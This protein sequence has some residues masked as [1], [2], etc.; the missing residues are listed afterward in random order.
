MEWRHYERGA[1]IIEQGSL[2][3]GVDL[4]VSGEVIVERSSAAGKPAQPIAKLGPGQI[5]G[6]RSVL[7]NEAT[8]ATVRAISPVKCL[9]LAAASFERLLGEFASLQHWVRDLVALRDRSQ[10][11]IDL[12]LRHSFLRPLGRDDLDRFI[13]SGRVRELQA[14]EPLVRAGERSRDV[15]FVISG[16]V[17][18]YAPR[19]E[20]RPREELAVQGAGWLFGHAAALLDLPRTADV[21]PLETTEILEVRAEALMTIVD[22]NPTVRRRLYQDLAQIDLHVEAARES[23]SPSMLVS[24]YG[25]SRALGTTSI[26]YA[27]AAALRDEAAVVL[28]DLEGRATADR[29]GFGVVE[30]RRLDLEVCRL[31]TPEDW[32]LDVVWPKR[33]EDVLG[34]LAKLRDAASPGSYVL[35]AAESMGQ[36]DQAAMAAAEAVVFVRWAS[37]RSHEEAA[38]RGQYRV[39]AVRLERGA[40]L[41]LETNSRT[42]RVA[43]DPDTVSRFWRSG[44]L[45]VLVD[46][47]RKFGRAA[48]RLMRVLLGRSVGLALGG[49]GALGFSHIGLI[50][51]LTDARI[52]IDYVSGASFG[53]LVA[54]LY[55]AGGIDALGELIKRR[56]KLLR[57]AVFAFYST[58][59]FETF[60]DEIVGHVELGDTEVPFFPVAVDISTG[61][62]VVRSKGT[63]GHGVRSSSCLPG[64]YPTLSIG[65]QRLVDGGMNNNVPASVVWEAGAHFI[66]ASNIIPS[67]PFGRTSTL[68]TGR[69]RMPARLDSLVRSLYLLMSQTGR[70]RAL[71]ADYV[72]DLAIQGY[73]IYDFHEG[74]AISDAGQRQAETQ[75]SDIRYAYNKA[76][77]I[78]S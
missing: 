30:E 76:C 10:T 63:I 18:V 56:N 75:L 32:R 44:D 61:R 22:R 28:V 54:G 34:L 55:T 52:P 19:V 27:L 26:A 58:E 53:A 35:V 67:F 50:K 64:A 23:G 47:Q 5:V 46:P 3:Y 77:G 25:T 65:G 59:G 2:G 62:E 48:H 71:L 43:D 1:T 11:L 40:L 15:F 72:F 38:Q 74:A 6:E 21:E 8:G 70:D 60:V 41:P 4:L 9:H 31:E 42:V 16:K 14:G 73:N 57:A 36:A 7:K 68:N 12:L 37:D 17:C 29:L 45:N 49:G 13:Q 24:I 51:A 20:G 39:D 78:Q 69:I 33:P 66:I